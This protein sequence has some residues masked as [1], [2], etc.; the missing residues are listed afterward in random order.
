MEPIKLKHG[1]AIIKVTIKILMLLESR[2]SAMPRK[3]DKI[4]I[5]SPE[6]IQ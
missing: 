5:G 2:K 6:R 4:I 3:G 1:V